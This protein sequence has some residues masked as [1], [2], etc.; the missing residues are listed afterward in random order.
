MAHTDNLSCED[1]DD[2]Y[3]ELLAIQALLGKAGFH[4]SQGPR[5]ALI[6]LLN[7]HQELKDKLVQVRL[8]A[9]SVD[10]RYSALLSTLGLTES[11]RPSVCFDPKIAGCKPL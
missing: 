11:D 10:A 3:E 2:Q 4:A 7:E 6:S 9:V 8:L 1:M 5:D